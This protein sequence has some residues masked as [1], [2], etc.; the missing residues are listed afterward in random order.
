[1]FPEY[2]E[3]R[4]SNEIFLPWDSKK[5]QTY[6]QHKCFS[7]LQLKT[8]FINFIFFF[9]KGLSI[10]YPKLDLGNIFKYNYAIFKIQVF[11]SHK[12][13]KLVPHIRNADVISTT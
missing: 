3:Q 8:Q 7:H 13:E 1:M 10:F 12:L 6:L 9:F 2:A 4:H 11:V 5:T